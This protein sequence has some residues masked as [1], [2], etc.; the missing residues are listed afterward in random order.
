MGGVPPPISLGFVVALQ[1]ICKIGQI[2]MF[3]NKGK[4]KIKM[5]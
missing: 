4:I 3:N 5:A 1:V 2:Q